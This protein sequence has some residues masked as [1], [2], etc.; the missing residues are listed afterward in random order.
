MNCAFI[1]CQTIKIYHRFLL[2]YNILLRFY[3]W[4]SFSKKMPLCGVYII[5]SSACVRNPSR[6]SCKFAADH[7]GGWYFRALSW[8]TEQKF[9]QTTENRVRGNAR[10]SGRN[11]TALILGH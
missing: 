1:N 6:G 2:L 4:P 3:S 10:E 5:R 9:M 7:V 11:T 8:T